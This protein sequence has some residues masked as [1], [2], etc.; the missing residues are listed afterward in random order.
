M[1][2]GGRRAT[3]DGMGE[4]QGHTRWYWGAAGPHKMVWGSHKATH[5]GMGELQGHTR[6]YGGA[7]GPH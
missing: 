6:R 1:V 5:D 7:A 2:W 3:Q 4:P